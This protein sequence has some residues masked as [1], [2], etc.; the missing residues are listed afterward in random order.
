K[1][2]HGDCRVPYGFTTEDGFGLGRWVSHKRTDYKVGRVTQD[3]I[4]ALN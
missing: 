2:E 4:D 3:R 1:A